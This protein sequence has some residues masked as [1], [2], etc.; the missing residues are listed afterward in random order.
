MRNN[1]V[2]QKQTYFDFSTNAELKR[3]KQLL[4]LLF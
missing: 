3:A 4:Y 1:Y 2:V